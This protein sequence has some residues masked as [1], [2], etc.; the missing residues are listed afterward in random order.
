[1]DIPKVVLVA[2]VEPR[3]AGRLGVIHGR[4]NASEGIKMYID[5]IFLC[6][7]NVLR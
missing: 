7:C 6:W 3:V 1:M 5:M 2:L 4:R